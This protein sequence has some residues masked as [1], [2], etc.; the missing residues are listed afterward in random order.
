LLGC[1][2]QQ[3][4]THWRAHV[5]RCASQKRV[6]GAE[7]DSFLE[8]VMTALTTWQPHMLVQFEDFANHN[9]FRLLE[10]FQHRC[11]CFN[12]DVSVLPVRAWT[13]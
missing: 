4:A 8:E 5:A 2:F 12:D 7:Y 13:D 6:T 11:A 10:N 9:A 1:G 3:H